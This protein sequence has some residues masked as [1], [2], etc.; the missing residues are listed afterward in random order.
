MNIPLLLITFIVGAGVIALLLLFVR[1]RRIRLLLEILT[2]VLTA[3]TGVLQVIQDQPQGN[4]AQR[5]EG[6]D[7]KGWGPGDRRLYAV[8]SPSD[9]VTFNSMVD[10]NEVIGDERFFLSASLYTGD[11]SKN[12]WT[13]HTDVQDGGEYVVRMYV[14]NNAAEDSGLTARDVRAY[15]ML[16][17]QPSDE[18]TIQG[19]LFCANAV[20]DAV[21]D[22][23]SFYSADGRPFLLQYVD[24]SAVYYTH[25]E[26][27]VIPLDPQMDS[28]VSSLY[29][30]SQRGIPL[31]YD[32][33]DGII[34]PGPKCAGF[35]TFHVTASFPG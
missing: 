35:L 18:L 5:N 25:L 15:I 10:N 33:L 21:W 19:K 29:L 14:H 1:D 24:G 28:S 27:D 31:G 23:T 30:F 26:E 4:G 11:A 34:P 17:E 13:D 20:P 3:A 6:N 32:S 8:A 22:S 16:P 2:I 9:Q 12:R 7:E